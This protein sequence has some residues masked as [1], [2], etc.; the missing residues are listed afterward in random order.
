MKKFIIAAVV[1]AGISAFTSC[2]KDWTC[3]CTATASGFT[4]SYDTTLTDM[5]KSDAESTCSGYNFNYG[6][7]GSQTCELK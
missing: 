7:L 1:I 2:K 5:K 4:I 3:S 6:S